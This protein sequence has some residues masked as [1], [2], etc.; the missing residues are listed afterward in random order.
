MGRESG[1]V[2]DIALNNASAFKTHISHISCTS[3][4][5]WWDQSRMFGDICFMILR[6]ACPQP[7]HA[8]QYGK[9]LEITLWLIPEVRFSRSVM[10]PAV[11][12]H[13]FL[14]M[15]TWRGILEE[16]NSQTCAVIAERF[17]VSE[18]T[19][20]L[21]SHCIVMAY[22]TT[23]YTAHWWKQT[24]GMNDSHFLFCFLCAQRHTR[25]L[26]HTQ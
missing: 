26:C 19:V 21:H 15:R 25:F 22:W 7:H 18:E 9:S 11:S 12:V 8:P 1:G 5:T 17:Q 13:K 16:Y 24:S 10:N 14:M 2:N 4:D 20:R 23:A 3:R 6:W